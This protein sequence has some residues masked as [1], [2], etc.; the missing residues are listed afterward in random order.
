MLAAVAA[1]AGTPVR[2]GGVKVS[3][4]SQTLDVKGVALPLPLRSEH[5]HIYAIKAAKAAF[6]FRSEQLK[7]S[8]L[9]EIKRGCLLSVSHRRHQSQDGA[10]G[11]DA[12]VTL[13]EDSP[14]SSELG[15]L[16]CPD[17]NKQ[18]TVAAFQGV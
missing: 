1:A 18:I 10:A 11:G 15:S 3:L 12:E 5:K 6:K 16:F 8:R 4:R 2:P 17:D 9:G 13:A 14:P 7:L